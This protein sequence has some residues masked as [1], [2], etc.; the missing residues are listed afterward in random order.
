VPVLV[1]DPTEIGKNFVFLVVEDSEIECA[2]GELVPFNQCAEGLSVGAQ[3]APAEDW[4]HLRTT[5]ELEQHVGV[6]DDFAIALGY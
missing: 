5:I 6:V 3:G 2:D 4:I 1:Q